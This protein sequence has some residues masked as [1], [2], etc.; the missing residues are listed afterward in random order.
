MP[1]TSP[2]AKNT[3]GTWGATRAKRPAFSRLVHHQP[4]SRA[5]ASSARKPPS[6]PASSA[7]PGVSAGSARTSASRRCVGREITSVCSAWL[8]ATEWAAS[9]D[10]T[11]SMREARVFSSHSNPIWVSA[12]S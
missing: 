5:A 7:R 8:A 12:W 2:G 4:I 9:C 11:A 6:H 10:S 1:S 3:A